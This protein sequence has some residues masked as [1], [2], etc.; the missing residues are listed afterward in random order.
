MR[1]FSIYFFLFLLVSG[2]AMISCGGSDDNSDSGDT[3]DSATDMDASDSADSAEDADADDV[4]D[5]GTLECDA[6]VTCAGMYD[7]ES[8]FYKACVE[9]AKSQAKTEYAAYA[10]CEKE[11]CASSQ[12]ADCMKKNCADVWTTCF[13]HHPAKYPTVGDSCY[14]GGTIAHNMTY[15]DTEWNFHQFADYYKTKKAILLVG[16]S[17]GC[18]FCTQEAKKIMEWY[19]EFG[20]EKFVAVEVLFASGGFEDMA[21]LTRWNKS[22]GGQHTGAPADIVAISAYFPPEQ[23]GTP[24]NVL[25]DGDTMEILTI[26]Q[27][28]DEVGLKQKIDFLISD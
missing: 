2:F 28:F 19:E 10:A 14:T 26:T 12:Y 9:K 24:Y 4:V 8:T 3:A 25:I 13:S 23:F 20:D 22:Y 7:A 15:Y 1:R 5:T 6:L 11:K 21:G 18:P 27:G 16:S 17:F